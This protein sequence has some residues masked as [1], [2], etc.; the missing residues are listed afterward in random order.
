MNAPVATFVKRCPSCG[1]ERPVIELVCEYVGADG[2]EC[3]Y[4]LVSRIRSSS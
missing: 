1:T 4:D 3:S 2:H